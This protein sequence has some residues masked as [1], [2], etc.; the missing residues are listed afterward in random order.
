MFR[1]NVLV[2]PALRIPSPQLGPKLTRSIK[3]STTSALTAFSSMLWVVSPA[4]TFEIALAHEIVNPVSVIRV[5]R[6]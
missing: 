2:P 6:T 1:R 5:N 4:L 3:V